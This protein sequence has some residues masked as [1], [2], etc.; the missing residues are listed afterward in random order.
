LFVVA[1]AMRFATF[2][3]RPRD[4]SL[5]ELTELLRT[6]EQQLGAIG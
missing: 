5:F 1:A 3:D 4:S 6:L 2:G